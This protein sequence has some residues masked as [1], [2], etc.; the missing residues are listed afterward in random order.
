MN[1]DMMALHVNLWILLWKFAQDGLLSG[2]I[3]A[4]ELMM[5]IEDQNQRMIHLTPLQIHISTQ[6]L[7]PLDQFSVKT[8]LTKM[9]CDL[10]EI[11]PIS[12]SSFTASATKE[13]RCMPTVCVLQRSFTLINCLFNHRLSSIQWMARIQ[14]F[15]SRDRRFTAH[16]SRSSGLLLLGR[17]QWIFRHSHD[18]RNFE[19]Q[20]CKW[21]FSTECR[22]T[23]ME[24]YIRKSGSAGVQHQNHTQRI[25]GYFFDPRGEIF[26]FW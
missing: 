11:T 2:L 12:D 1:P 7:C 5:P 4:W 3:W 26:I 6:T 14:S 24:R 20:L 19:D 9:V 8:A 21:C 25:C 16:S 17:D 22:S 10:I 15:V 18:R 13:K 23:T